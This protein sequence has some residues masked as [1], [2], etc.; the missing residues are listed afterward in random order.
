MA[1]LRRRD[2]PVTILHSRAADSISLADAIR[3]AVLDRSVAFLSSPGRYQVA[4]VRDSACHGPVGLCSLDE[5]FEA[6]AFNPE[7][8]MRWLHVDSGL[9]RAVV[10]AE[11]ERA[12]PTAFGQ[13][14]SPLVAA[15]VLPQRYMLWGRP[16]PPRH[17]GWISLYA[18]RIGMLEV[19][20]TASGSGRRAYLTAR[21]Y[22]SVEQD[23][24][25]AYVAEERLLTLE[26]DSR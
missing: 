2:K 18:A 1:V 10:L 3:A 9:G 26:E 25:N 24:G 21:E 23:H 4:E 17:D 6:R 7:A 11:D 14:L 13:P 22:I 19:P 12:L 5:V 20:L 16:T 8:E 15:E